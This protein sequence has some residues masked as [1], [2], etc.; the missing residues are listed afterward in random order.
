MGNLDAGERAIQ[1]V[2]RTETVGFEDDEVGHLPALT[3]DQAIY[4]SFLMDGLAPERANGAFT[5]M[6][7][8]PPDFEGWSQ[9]RE[10]LQAL[11]MIDTDRPTLF[12]AMTH[13]LFGTAFRTTYTM[14]GNPKTAGKGVE[15]L[16]RLHGLLIDRVKNET[17]DEVK[18]L[19]R[20]LQ[21][22]YRPAEQQ[23]FTIRSD[24]ENG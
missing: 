21:G 4:V 6:L 19:Y 16:L 1:K 15:L 18:K 3:F 17:P 9:N 2:L 8:S 20:V 14:L 11:S 10:F 7:S 22:R 5:K 23:T 24:S 13:A 12:K